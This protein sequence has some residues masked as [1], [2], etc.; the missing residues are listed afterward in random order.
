MTNWLLTRPTRTPATV[1]SNGI[2]EIAQGRRG[3]GDGEHVGVVVGVGRHDH[4]DDLRLVAPAGGEERPDRAVDQPAGEHFLFGRLALALEEAARDAS[5]RRRRIRGSR[6]SAAGKSTSRGLAAREAATSTIVSPERTITE[7][8]AC[9]ASL[10]V[11]IEMVREP[12]RTSR[13]CR[14]HIVHIDT[15]GWSGIQ[16]LLANPKALD[17]VRVAR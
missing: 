6:P 2:S 14:F 9:L 15:L 16:R 17:Q 13:R 12:T 11:S 5:R 10:P 4:P 1:F 8:C 3:A 7:P